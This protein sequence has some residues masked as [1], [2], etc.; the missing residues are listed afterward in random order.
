MLSRMRVY[1]SI[2]L[3]RKIT[4]ATKHVFR[5][6]ILTLEPNPRSLSHG[7]YEDYIALFTGTVRDYYTEARERVASQSTSW[8]PKS[9]DG[10]SR[11]I[12]HREKIK[13]DMNPRDTNQWAH[14]GLGGIELG[15]S[16]VGK[17]NKYPRD[18]SEQ[19]R[20]QG[21][22]PQQIRNTRNYQV[23]GGYLALGNAL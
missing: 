10:G 4:C 23:D 11:S 20:W 7:P 13:S 2:L 12:G 18:K 19:M 6:L 16:S 1:K 21:I 5:D 22:K 9:Q 17:V 3:Y 14:L 15:R 8:Q